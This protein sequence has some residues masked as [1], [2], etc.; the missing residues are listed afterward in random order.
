MSTMYNSSRRKMSL[1]T[2]IFTNSLDTTQSKSVIGDDAAVELERKKQSR[3][4]TIHERLGH[5]SF[6]VLKL[7]ARCGIVPRELTSVDPLTVL[8]VL[9]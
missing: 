2:Q 1:T 4:L 5:I 7:M 8:A 6:S 3:L 9:M